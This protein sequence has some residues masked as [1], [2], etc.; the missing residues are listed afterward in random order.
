M[1]YINFIM[2]SKDVISIDEEQAMRILASPQQLIVIKGADGQWTGETIN[3]AH[4]VDTQ[5]DFDRENNEAREEN[6]KRL[7]LKDPGISPKQMKAN[8]KRL[9]KMRKELTEKLGWKK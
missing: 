5:R 3:K 2:S 8:R 9:D 6:S 7:K 1:R 4:I